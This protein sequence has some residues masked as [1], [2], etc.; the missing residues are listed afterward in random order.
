MI[1]WNKYFDRIYCIHFVQY[2]KRRQLLEFELNRVGILNSG[3]FQYQFT[4]RSNIKLCE[5]VLTKLP[6][7]NIIRNYTYI[8]V[9]LGHY[10]CI[11]QAYTKGYERILILEDDVRFLKDLNLI[12][13]I[14]QN[15]P[16]DGNII[17]YDKSIPDSYSNKQFHSVNDYYYSFT[18]CWSAACYQLDRKGM[19]RLLNL[20]ES[21]NQLR[22]PDEYFY[23]T[24]LFFNNLHCYCS[25]QNMAIQIQFKDSELRKNVSINLE[26]INLSLYIST[27]TKGYKYLNINFDDYMIRKD[28]AKFNYGDFII[29]DQIK[30]LI[31]TDEEE[32]QKISTQQSIVPTNINICL[33]IPYH[34]LD[35]TLCIIESLLENSKSKFNIFIIIDKEV[36]EEYYNIFKFIINQNIKI[37]LLN[38][39]YSLKELRKNKLLISNLFSNLDRMLYLD[40]D[41]IIMKKGIEWLYNI[42]FRNNHIATV[43]EDNGVI[44]FNLNKIREDKSINRILKLNPIFNNSFLFTT[45]KLNSVMFLNK[46]REKYGF[47]NKKEFM[48]NFIITHFKGKN[49]PWLLN[50]D[51][52]KNSEYRKQ[53]IIYY[54]IIKHK[55]MEKANEYYME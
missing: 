41:T 52:I 1:Q 45:K 14:L 20:M 23:N 29:E 28:G 15:K 19:E 21:F 5:C 33:T 50:I 2:T 49:K 27:I 26:S 54:N 46:I 22:N 24:P 40:Y 35:K 44:L 39:K 6:Y 13:Q 16:K 8:S 30:E 3:I 32:P 7:S 55:I 25:K 9:I 34:R 17:L 53:Y 4:D 38:S 18:Y 31:L 42:D 12:Q 37:K 36:K 48:D 51:N 10:Y 43:K 47:E 11:R